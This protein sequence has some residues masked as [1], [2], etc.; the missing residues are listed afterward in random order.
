M[1]F[2][3]VSDIATAIYHPCRCHYICVCTKRTSACRKKFFI[4]REDERKSI[5][6]ERNVLRARGGGQRWTLLFSIPYVFLVTNTTA[7]PEELY[8]L[9]AKEVVTWTL[10]WFGCLWIASDKK[11]I[12]SCCSVV[13]LFCYWK[14]VLKIWKLSQMTHK[15][16]KF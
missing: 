8:V 15:N 13:S 3:V 2:V 10:Q 12:H 14:K 7:L 1:H 6:T 9:S 11:D 16:V 5:G 4:H